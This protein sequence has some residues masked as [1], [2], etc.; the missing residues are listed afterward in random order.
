MSQ[1]VQFDLPI[2]EVIPSLLSAI[3]QQTQVIL[4][5]PPGAGKSTRFPQR[6]MA[7]FSPENRIILL[8]PRRLAARNIA[9][10]LAAQCGEKVGESVGLRVR[11][12]TKVSAKT[13]IEIV[14]E[15]VLTRMI[16][17][18]PDLEG[19]GCII[20]D[21]FH[22]RSLH[23]DT[24]LALCLDV[25]EALRDDLKLVVMS[26]TLD[27]EALKTLM[28]DATYVESAGRCYP[29]EHRYHPVAPTKRWVPEMSQIIQAVMAKEDGSLLAFLPGVGEIK[30]LHDMLEGQLADNIDLCPL[31]GQLDI[32]QQQ[33]AILPAKPGR[34]KVVLATNI[35]ETSLTIEGVRLVVDSGLERTVTW[36]PK[37][38]LSR[39]E[40]TKIAQSSAEQRAGRAGRL[41]SGICIRLYSESQLLAQPK[42][43]VPEILRSDLT[44]LAME[45]S[46]WGCPDGEGLHWLDTPPLGHLQQAKEWLAWAGITTEKGQLS[47][48]G[49]QVVERGSEPRHGLML[50][51][52]E[53]WGA[54]AKACVAVLLS[55]LENP[56]RG[57][58]N[59]D[60][61]R[62]VYMVS[63]NRQQY[64]TQWQRAQQWAS[65]LSVSLNRNID[66][67]WVGLLLAAGY[68]DR[69]G[70]NRG[71]GGRFALSG[72]QGVVV[73]DTAV[74]ADSDAIVVVDVMRTRQ[75][76]ARVFSAADINFDDIEARL[77]HLFSDRDWSDWDDK[78]GRLIAE[79]QHCCGELI[80]SRQQ[81]DN[82]DAEQISLA[83]LH[84]VQR[85]GIASLPWESRSESLLLR[86]RY[87]CELQQQGKLSDLSLPNL[88]DEALMAEAEVWLLPFMHGMKSWASVKKIELYNALE[89]WFG[90]DVTQ[91]LN[92]LLPTHYQVP[93]GSN[94]K[95]R[96]PV[97]SA[98]V[99]SVRMQEMYG[100]A[101]TPMVADGQV[102]L[103]VELLSPAQRPLQVTQDLAVFWTGSYREVQK[104]MKG[105]YP[106]HVWP[107]DPASHIAT[108]KTK[109]HF[110]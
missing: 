36:D 26:A 43:P 12:E 17:T 51:Y 79:K 46:Q 82:P 89:A 64:R 65:K 49:Q 31:Y 14:T 78:R 13:R 100:E 29:V 47:S 73:D 15:G 3:S 23:A 16:Q 9:R 99:L 74:L 57:Q 84:A 37:A 101:N 93:T 22:E 69:L 80:V 105:R 44:P 25:Q 32:N 27:G 5:A 103:V 4:Q 77:P 28:P 19:I 91:Q 21:E 110:Q 42:Q 86:A 58:Q 72:G 1:P 98:P 54:D 97:S 60:L 92:R 83:I 30:Q 75:G 53:Q 10:F 56:L 87:A 38:G 71:Q 90:W 33:A 50:S 61:S 67:S 108:T 88:S 11:G 45:L 48:L 94:I 35:A 66:L 8:E 20:F 68:P 102:A 76:D 70:M 52:A 107:D 2:D 39:L 41:S 7:A 18:S 81:L 63:D 104:E 6:L 85:K 40:S 55:V 34:R 24:A 106:K 62:Q 109:R 95:L 59:P 96:Y